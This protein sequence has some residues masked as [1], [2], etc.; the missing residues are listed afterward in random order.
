MGLLNFLKRDRNKKITITTSIGEF[1]FLE[2]DGTKNY[3]G[4]V[5]SKI[6]DD[7][8]VLFPINDDSISEYQINYFKKIEN[9]WIS[10]LKQ[11]ST[12]KPDIHFMDYTV[13]SILIPDKGNKFYDVDAEIVI[14]KEESV[15]S[16]I[17]ADLN[18]DEIIEPS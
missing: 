5:K 11:I 12:Q 13:V 17:M 7:I 9:S 2:I 10:I 1:Y 18:V 14:Q 4:K 8:E 3:Q 15:F 16:L 6:N